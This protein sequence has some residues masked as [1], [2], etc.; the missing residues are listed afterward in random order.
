MVYVCGDA[1]NN[2]SLFTRQ[3]M[4]CATKVETGYYSVPVHLPP[5]GC[6]C[7]SE[8]GLLGDFTGLMIS[9]YEK[10]SIL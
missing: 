10:H 3:A 5:V 9:V 8:D 6:H 7:G 4:W 2:S 1:R